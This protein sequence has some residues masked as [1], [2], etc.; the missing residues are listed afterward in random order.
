MTTRGKV[1]LGT[2]QRTGEVCKESGIWKADS[3]PS[4]TIPLAKTNIFPP[5]R[6]KAVVWI[7]I[8]HA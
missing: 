6:G 4:T 1:P 5:Y 7:L 3:Y 8:L 2:R